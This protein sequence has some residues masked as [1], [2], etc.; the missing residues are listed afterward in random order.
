MYNVFDF[1]QGHRA[2]CVWTHEWTSGS[3]EEGLNLQESFLP[4]L[5]PSSSDCYWLSLIKSRCFYLP[6]FF[7]SVMWALPANYDAVWMK[8][9]GPE[10]SGDSLSRSKRTKSDKGR[11]ICIQLHH[12]KIALKKLEQ[13]QKPR[14]QKPS[15]NRTC[16]LCFWAGVWSPRK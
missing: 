13:P 15:L 12:W 5:P 11:E 1:W 9:W 3:E 4:T 6:R 16:L 8:A 14:G 10:G 2:L 7:C